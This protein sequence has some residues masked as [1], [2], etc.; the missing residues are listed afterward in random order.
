MVGSVSEPNKPKPGWGHGFSSPCALGACPATLSAARASGFLILRRTHSSLIARRNGGRQSGPDSSRPTRAGL[1]QYFSQP[2]HGPG[3]RFPGNA[4]PPDQIGQTPD[5][6]GAP[7]KLLPRLASSA[8]SIPV[9]PL[10]RTPATG[11]CRFGK[12]LGSLRALHVSR[13]L[14]AAFGAAYFGRGNSK[15]V[16]NE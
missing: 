16:W 1:R 9:I 12:K 7:E 11:L 10:G 13:C 14:V 8:A 3:R 6:L 5:D 4:A 2:R 15:P